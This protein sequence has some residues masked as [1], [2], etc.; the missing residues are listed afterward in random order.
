MAKPENKRPVERRKD[1]TIAP[2]ASGN[3]GGRPKGYADFR[4]KC[5][6]HT[7]ASI[8]RL[9]AALSDERL[10]VQAAQTLLAYGWGKPSSA[11]EDNEALKGLNPFEGMTPEELAAY[12]KAR[13]EARESRG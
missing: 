12:L 6:E 9:V 10:C 8:A 13:R 3:P 5:R 2:G 7:D 1:G 4:E 11:P